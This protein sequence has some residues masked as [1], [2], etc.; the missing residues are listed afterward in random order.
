MLIRLSIEKFFLIEEQELNFDPGLNVITGE[1][2]TGKSMTVSTLLFL[3]GQQGDYPEGTAVELEL[4]IDGE[5]YVIRREIKNRRSRFYLNGIGST[6]KT[7]KEIISKALIFQGQDDRLKILRKD[8]QRD[9]FD[10]TVGCYSTRKSFEELYQKLEEVSKK[11]DYLLGLEREIKIRVIEEELKEIEKVGWSEE[12]YID[13]YKTVERYA[14]VEKKNKLSSEGVA[15]ID[16]LLIPSV[17]NLAKLLGE[18]GLEQE[19]QGVLRMQEELFNVRRRLLDIYENIDPD[20]IN[21]L[22][23][24]IF[25]VQRLERKYG[26]KYGEVLKI[27]QELREELE[28]LRSIET[29]LESLQSL[30]ESLHRELRSLGEEL[31]TKRRQGKERFVNLVLGHLKDL[32]LE[33]AL[34]DVFFEKQEGRFGHE[35][36]R[37]V[38]SS[39]GGE[40]R[41][42]A[43]VASGG[44]ISRI[45]LSLFLLSPVAETYLLDEID[46]GVSGQTSVKVAKFLKRLSSKMQVIVITH[47][48]ALASAADKHFKT[49]RE[50]SRVFIEELKEDRL[51]EIARLMGIV[52]SQTINGAME[53]IREVS[54]V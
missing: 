4:S 41:D 45:A 7:V 5:E 1:T 11:I 50:G 9:V 24:R 25:L 44:E 23:E 16:S 14:E 17:K 15:Q 33:G 51:E 12:E 22:N 54:N 37:F 43:Q 52:N 42:L 6:Q 26:R 48:P 29:D 40:L 21:Q 31:S 20:Y 32:G 19:K 2:G 18:L 47:S 34:F 38:F 3:L 35:D 30:R 46:V 27:A 36:I 8:F 53:L 13:A 10:K 39:Y 49:Y 28:R